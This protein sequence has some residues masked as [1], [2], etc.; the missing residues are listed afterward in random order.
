MIVTTGS[1]ALRV[2][3]RRTTLALVEALG[4]GGPD[5]VEAEDLE[6]A[7]ARDPGDD[8]QRDRPQRDRRQDQVAERVDDQR[9]IGR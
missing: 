6:Q 4:P 2:A 3:W 7:G 5:V 9:P 1:R 8:R